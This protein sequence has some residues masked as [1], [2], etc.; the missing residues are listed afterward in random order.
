M[1]FLK[2]ELKT[3]EFLKVWYPSVQDLELAYQ[4]SILVNWFVY[5]I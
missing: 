5:A 4:A 2:S 1:Y 3:L